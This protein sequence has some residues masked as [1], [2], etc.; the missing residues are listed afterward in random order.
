MLLHEL[1]HL[2][3]GDP[4]WRLV[5]D[6]ATALLWWHPLV[7][8]MRRRMEAVSEI[9]ADEA[10]L[11]LAD[12]PG[13]LAE[14]LVKLGA[15][16]AHGQPARSLGMA[17]TGFRSGLGRRVERLV[18]LKEQ[19]WSP[20]C[21][22]RSA[23]A[24]L[25]GAFALVLTAILCTAWAVPAALTKGE[26]MQTMQHTWKHSLA[27]FALLATLGTDNHTAVAQDATEPALA[28]RNQAA[29]AEAAEAIPGAP[30]GYPATGTVPLAPGYSRQSSA[31]ASVR[32][33]PTHTDPK[34]GSKEKQ[35]VET[36]LKRI[37]LDTVNFDGVAL[38]DVVH[39]LVDTAARL[40]PDKSGI[41]F[42]VKLETQPAAAGGP[43]TVDP[44][45][46]LPVATP[47]ETLDLNNVTIKLE[48]PL[49]HVRMVDVLDAITKV[50]DHPIK[51]SIEDYGVLFSLD[52]SKLT[53]PPVPVSLTEM[54]SAKT[55]KVDTNTFIAGLESAFGIR[56]PPANARLPQETQEALRSLLA[57]LG[58]NLDV[59]N[60][61]I[62]YN[63]L[64]GI[65]MVRGTQEDLAVVQAAIET[66]GGSE[67]SASGPS[68][69]GFGGSAGIGARP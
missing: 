21:P 40:D 59:P 16:L 63:Q 52:Q 61:S 12:G 49:K 10:S 35:A 19:V 37:T 13:A 24:R 58:I 32:V 50:A 51:Y 38:G 31:R 5:A 36:K 23:L 30:P 7:W 62:F 3:A 27:A 67:Y 69:P 45:T 60:K 46:G 44:T 39:N 8:W 48:P 6:I 14:C 20:P 68:S 54:L 2:R 53:G 4:V 11:L 42:L 9:V 47:M 15:Q 17:V 66:L 26:N 29:S 22:R 56:L 57:Q 43:M 64:T 28:P 33:D 34:A 41:N 25:G 65:L 55:F 18:H 1:A